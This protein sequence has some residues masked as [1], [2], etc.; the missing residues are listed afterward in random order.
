[1]IKEKSSLTID[2]KLKS[3]KTSKITLPKLKKSK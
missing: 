2:D 1:L 3:V